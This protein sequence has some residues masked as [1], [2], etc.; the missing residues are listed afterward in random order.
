MIEQDLGDGYIEEALVLQSS[1]YVLEPI[2]ASR[3]LRVGIF[4]DWEL[5]DPYV[6]RECIAQNA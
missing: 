4:T 2:C 3:F 6:W 1:G 5:A